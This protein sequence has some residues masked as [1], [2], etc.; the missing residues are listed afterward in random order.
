MS[1][2][3][4]SL[5]NGVKALTAH[6]RSI[7]T[8]GRNLANVNNAGYARQRVVYGDRGTVKTELGAQSLG[9]EAKS[10]QQLRDMLLDRQVVR[11]KSI[12]SSFEAEQAAYQKAQAALGQSI[13]RAGESSSTGFSG[14]GSGIAESLSEFFNSFQSLAARPTDPG[15]RETLIQNAGILTDRIRIT[16]TRL[17]QLQSDLTSQ[18]SNDV[19]D[20]NRI[21]TSIANLNAEIGRFEIAQPG[22]AVDLR[23]QRQSLLEELA[24]KMNFETAVDPSGSGQ[25]QVIAR[26]ASNN[27]IVLVD[28][29]SVT[30]PLSLS[31]STL[32][33]GSPSTALVVSGGSISGTI[34]ARD[35]AVQKLRDDLDALSKQ[36]VVSVNAAYDPTNST[37]KFF[38]PA[39]I[40]A[41]TI[42][43]DGALTAANLKATDTGGAAGDNAIAKAVADLA[44]TSFS[45]TATPA[46]A[47]DGTYSQHFARM[48]SQLGQSLASTNLKVQDQTNIE[49]LVRTQRDAV[50]GVSMDEE[51]SDLMKYQRAFQASSRV[52]Q[53][54]SELLEN[55]VNLGRA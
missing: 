14:N 9:I 26:D 12:K 21:L 32:S 31:G 40:T 23:D 48:V 30:G 28:K 4:G 19:D 33:G 55:V 6:S 3:F 7:E 18:A 25:I 10:I 37:G 22:G 2:L 38:N 35:G 13:D 16:D 34:T 42:S 41:A 43:I 27:P 8:A 54:I 39:N 47:I 5:A 52:I 24:T 50:S 20:A 15:Q 29:A 51:M 44:S 1:G 17:N 36:L 53:V 49:Q 11:E 46:D 45:T